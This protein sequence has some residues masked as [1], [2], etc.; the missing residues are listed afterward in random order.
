MTFPKAFPPQNSPNCKTFTQLFLQIIETFPIK[1]SRSQK[2]VVVVVANCGYLLPYLLLLDFFFII[3]IILF[4]F[5]GGGLLGGFRV[6]SFAF[7]FWGYFSNSFFYKKNKL[8]M[9][10]KVSQFNLDE[11]NCVF[12]THTTM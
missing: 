8:L 10:S 1:S 2:Q 3:I 12:L 4:L 5:F 11:E 6:Y 7:S 9:F